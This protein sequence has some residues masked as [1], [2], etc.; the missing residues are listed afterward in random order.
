MNKMMFLVLS[1]VMVIMLSSS[2]WSA[3]EDP[4][5]GTGLYI[6]N[7]TLLDVWY[8]RNGGPCTIW[9]HTHILTMKPE[10]TLTIYSDMTCKTLYCSENPTYNVYKSLD[11]NQNCRVKILPDCTLSDM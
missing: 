10:D 11:G 5:R 9:V 7:Q 8:M 3:D 1:L 6:G 2:V 4:C